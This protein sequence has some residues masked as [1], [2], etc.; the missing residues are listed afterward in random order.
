MTPLQAL[1]QYPKF[2]H[3][4]VEVT[5]C[6]EEESAFASSK[7]E[8]GQGLSFLSRDVKSSTPRAVSRRLDRR[9]LDS[10]SLTPR[11]RY[12][13]VPSRQ[14]P[15]ACWVSKTARLEI[16]YRELREWIRGDATPPPPAHR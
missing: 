8:V 2:R 7:P 11:A 15:E 9:R 16:A 13:R 5:G 10:S 6:I 14:L 12:R 1:A 4:H 3:Y